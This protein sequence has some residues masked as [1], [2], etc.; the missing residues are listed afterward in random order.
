M[1][2]KDQSRRD[3]E[4]IRHDYVVLEGVIKD[5]GSLGGVFFILLRKGKVLGREGQVHG[6]GQNCM[7]GVMNKLLPFITMG[8]FIDQGMLERDRIPLRTEEKRALVNRLVKGAATGKRDDNPHVSKEWTGLT[9]E[10]CA[11]IWT[12]KQLENKKQAWGHKWFITYLAERIS[13]AVLVLDFLLIFCITTAYHKKI[14]LLYD[15]VTSSTVN[16]TVNMS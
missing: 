10:R 15:P 4:H 12:E 7:A 1:Y 14:S 9:S 3:L 2:T 13:A 8:S 11:I 6:P 5:I 16:V